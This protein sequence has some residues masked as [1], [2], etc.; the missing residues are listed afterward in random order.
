MSTKKGSQQKFEGLWIHIFTE[1]HHRSLQQSENDSWARRISFGWNDP[2]QVDLCNPRQVAH[3][4]TASIKR[5]Q[6]GITKIYCDLENNPPRP[7]QLTK[8]FF[9][10]LYRSCWKYRELFQFQSRRY[11]VQR[12]HQPLPSRHNNIDRLKHTHT[13]RIE[14]ILHICPH[15]YTLQSSEC[16]HVDPSEHQI[17]NQKRAFISRSL[18]GPAS[19]P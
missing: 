19:D 3:E 11:W 5:P 17:R 12:C 7:Q 13:H 9:K 10:L 14:A 6:A 8:H 4:Y 2:N 16:V 15:T 1:W 18:T